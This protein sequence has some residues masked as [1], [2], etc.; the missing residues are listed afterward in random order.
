MQH[1]A[2]QCRGK[3]RGNMHRNADPSIH[4][5]L[6]WGSHN[7]QYK[8]LG[9]LLQCKE[10]C[11]E[12]YNFVR[13][14]PRIRINPLSVSLAVSLSRCTLQEGGRDGCNMYGGMYI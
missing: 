12:I 8:D 10:G 14:S 3:A 1:A 7:A 6:I 13:P 5:N 11:L 4:C 2:V 9:I